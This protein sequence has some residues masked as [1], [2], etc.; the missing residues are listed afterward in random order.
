MASPLLHQQTRS[1]SETL[2]T[3]TTKQ[4]RSTVV[5]CGD[6]KC[7]KTGD[8]HATDLLGIY[9]VGMDPLIATMAGA[10]DRIGRNVVIILKAAELDPEW[11][12]AIL[13][14]FDF[15]RGLLEREAEALLRLLPKP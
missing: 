8:E 13:G 2:A 14:E 3:S 5:A 11:A 12:D 7:K 4:P 10:T 9:A 1:E 15:R 6:P